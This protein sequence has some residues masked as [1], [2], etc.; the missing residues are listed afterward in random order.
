M[1]KFIFW[2]LFQLVNLCFN[3]VELTTDERHNLETS[4]SCN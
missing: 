1:L 4:L 3:S 2:C